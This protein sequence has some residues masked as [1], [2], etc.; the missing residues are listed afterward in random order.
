MGEWIKVSERLPA[1][2]ASVLVYMPEEVPLSTVQEG[3][4]TRTGQ[5]F[6]G[7]FERK[8]DEVVAWREMP[9]PPEAEK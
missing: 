6:A 3:F 1:P 5:W 9:A 4:I 7:G 2:F 8:T